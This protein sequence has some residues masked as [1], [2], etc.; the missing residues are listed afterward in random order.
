MNIRPELATDA[1]AIS[2][3]LKR[4]FSGHAHSS[5]T[6]S[7]IVAALRAQSALAVS[8]VAEIKGRI[9]GHVAFSLVTVGNGA[10]H[11][12]GLGPLAVEPKYQR[13]GI[14]ASLVQQGLE[15]LRQRGAAGC[16]VLG[17][18]AY[19][20]RFG[21]LANSGITC[22]GPPPEYFMALMLYG[23]IATGEVRYHAAFAVKG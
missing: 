13:L 3:L 21:F 16:V 1:K 6:E 5:G 8:L 2:A 10:P 22:P 18:P 14:G 12:Y 4:A 11:W 7:A 19:Y 20:G 17:D 23:P 9:V 15:Q